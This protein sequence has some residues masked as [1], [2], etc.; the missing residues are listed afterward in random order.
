[1]SSRIDH[2]LAQGDTMAEQY[3]LTNELTGVVPT[4]NLAT[5]EVLVKANL[6]DAD[7]GALLTRRSTVAA[8]IAIDD[9]ANWKFTVK[10]TAAETAALAV[11]KHKWVC[12][13]IDDG[14]TPQTQEGFRGT[15]QV[16]QQGSD[17]SS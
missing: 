5:V 6:S 8:E 13:T 4:T 11:G 1:M 7:A 9:A 16:R 2:K 14:G 12:T 17:P 15:F 10:A 3:Q